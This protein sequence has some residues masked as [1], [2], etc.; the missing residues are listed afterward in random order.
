MKQREVKPLR[1][2]SLMGLSERQLKEHH[3][4]LYKGYVN[5]M[6]EIETKLGSTDWTS[7][8]ATYSEPRELLAEQTF[9][10]NAIRLHESYFENMGDSAGRPSG[11]IEGLIT[12]EFGSMDAFL[13]RFKASGMCARGWTVLAYDWADDRLSIYNCDAHNIGCVWDCSLLLVLDVYEHAYFI[14]YGTNRKDYLEAFVDNVNW[15]VVNDRVKRAGIM[16]RKGAPA[17]A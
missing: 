12:D 8:N 17:L 15:T 7:F 14:D 4:V 10:A 3:D 1:Y 13:E 5:K 2:S 6:A 11:D 16:E 9:A